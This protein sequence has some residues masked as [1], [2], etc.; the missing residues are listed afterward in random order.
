V[1]ICKGIKPTYERD[2]FIPTFTVALV[3]MVKIQNQSTRLS[4]EEQVKNMG[5]IYRMASYPAMK[6]NE[7]LSFAVKWIEPEDC[8]YKPDTER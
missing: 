8:P 2:T 1:Y 4:T 3:R 7:I 5:Y 6:K